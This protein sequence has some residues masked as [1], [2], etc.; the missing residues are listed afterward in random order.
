MELSGETPSHIAFIGDSYSNDVMGSKQV[1]LSPILI[2]REN[3][4][5]RTNTL[6]PVIYS[7]DEL[8]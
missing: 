5:N 1:G 6:I 2:D 7:L 4:V 8:R 3:K